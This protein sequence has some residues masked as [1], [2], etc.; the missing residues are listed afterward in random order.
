MRL[1]GK[2][3]VVFGAGQ[4]PGLTIGNGR[5]TSLVFAREGATVVAVDINLDSANETVE[6][7]RG[8]G[9][10]AVA[11]QADVTDESAI[12]AVFARCVAEHDRLDIMHLNVGMSLG[13]GDA[14]VTEIDGDAFD[15]IMTVNLKSMVLA[16]KHALPL[17]RAQEAGVIITISSA[18]AVADYPYISY[19]TSKAGVIALTQQVAIENAKYGIRA[20][21]IL[22]GL[23]NTPMA[24]ENRVGVIGATR[25]EVIARRDA[26]VPLGGRQGT[27]FDVANAALFLASDEAR[28]ITGVTLPVDGGQL[29][30]VG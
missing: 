26:Q 1:D 30:K 7:I 18:M 13:G 28:F 3:A 29:L 19:K 6:Q 20:N 21:C 22:P 24:I 27:A 23:M 16:C 10:S 14:R 5:A 12:E 25:E 8:L 2:V 9:G 15:R 4:T 11:V 17:M